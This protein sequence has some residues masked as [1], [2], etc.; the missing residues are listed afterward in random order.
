MRHAFFARTVCLLLAGSMLSPLDAG[1]QQTGSIAGLVT[2]A[3]GSVLPGV[4]VEASSPA[5]IE[6]VRIV[7]TDGTGQYRI[8]D[9]RPG[10]YTVTF[11][12]PSFSTVRRD[13][14]ELSVGFTA[15][16]NAEMRVGT[17]E[18]TIT[19]EGSSPIVD[20]QNVNQIKVV[21]RELIDTIPTGRG[22]ANFATLVPG[23]NMSNSSLNI[24]QDVGGGT[25]YNFAFA[26]IHGGRAMDQQVM[27][28][29]MSVTS[30][31][32]TGGTRT[33]WSDGTA[34]EYG[35]QLA[36]HSAEIAYGGVFANILPRDGGN[37]LSGD[38]FANF[39]TEDFQADNL[40][41]DL[42]RQGLTV[43]NKT[44][45]MVDVNPSLGGP[46][47]RDKLWFHTAFRYVVTDN[48]VGGLY[49]NATPTAW[50]FTP[51]LSRPAISDQ[52]TYDTT[53]NLTWQMSP[54]NRLSVFGTYD[55]LCLCHF[56]ISPTV[57]PE[58][59]TYNPGD[60]SI[61][62]GRWTSTLSN[63]L[64]VEAGASHYLSSFPRRPQPDAT[65]PSILEQSTNLR[66][67]SGATYFPTPQT[68]DDYRASISYVTGAHSL[69][70]GFTYQWEFA[71]DPVVFTIGDVNYRTLNG[72]PNQV[73]Y[74][75]TPYAAPLYLKPFGLFVQD[76]LKI[77]RWTINAGLRYD[78]FRTSY[79]AIHL[80]PVRW[81]PEAR[82]YPGAEVLNWKDLSP[83]LGVAYDLFGT[84][85]TAVKFSMS[86]YVLQ[87]GKGNTNNVH[88]VIAATNSVS[89]T[90]TD[91]NRDFV[92]QGDPLNPATNGELG[93]SPNSNFGKPQTTLRFDPDW[94]TG[95]NTRPYNW[96]M[97]VS[98][99]HELVPRV[100][101]EISYNRR[102]YGNFIVNDNTLVSPLDYDPYCITSPSDARFPDGG[103][104]QICGLFDLKPTKVGQVDTIR[105]YAGKYGDQTETWNGLDATTQIRFQGGATIQGGLSLG[106]QTT[107][108]CD[109]VGKLDNPSPYQCHRESA[110]L[111]QVKLLGSYQLP[112]W[113]LQV[114]GTFQSQVPDPVGGANF[115][116]NYFGLP[117]NYVA[118]SAQ[119]APSLGRPLSSGGTVTINVVESGTLYPGRT[120]Q[121]DLRVARRFTF[122]QARLQ[123]MVDLYNLFNSN[124][125]LRMNG[126]YGSD[127]AAWA[128][129]QAIVPGRLLKLGAQVSF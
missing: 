46:L 113:D 28:N 14:I 10:V 19:V 7:V 112:W 74:Y 129:P 123:G 99:Q 26:A 47:L 69:K 121:F 100:G 109:I 43:V 34:Q 101:I 116:Y 23:V 57:A 17:V 89:R 33:N 4:T 79:D 122:G 88:P 114:S 119:I 13:G 53:L 25:G 93:P 86:R 62:Q 98:V 41:D 126:A 127:G 58:A 5:L 40:D 61:V 108:N 2:D 22:Y 84:G 128:R 90:W 3:S 110:F 16:V 65:E 76:Q 27:V 8:V 56:S 29:G 48:Y 12:L 81:L 55:D 83:R 24:S 96:E 45:R 11:Q 6:K 59:A 60:S 97:L 67:R 72:V 104:Q 36:A 54:N 106:R 78:Q 120:N 117:A 70:A 115:D 18:E 82:D 107:D 50:T 31:T 91:A 118:S 124:N 1:A 51:D 32:G 105:T 20:I 63:E 49:Y 125:V 52:I 111:P 80:D 71:K 68:V 30:L 37:R 66:F 38:L 87:E 103:G 44:K 35:L 15:T 73:T 42:R 95:F 39:A 75:T 94:A 85:R 92:V 21:N 9:L 64:L 77:R 102:A